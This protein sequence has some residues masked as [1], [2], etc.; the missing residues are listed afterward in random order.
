MSTIA[1]TKISPE[2]VCLVNHMV[3]RKNEVPT[4]LS[5]KFTESSSELAGPIMP[6]PRLAV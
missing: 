2:K 3:G 6:K 1:T 4:A 5:D